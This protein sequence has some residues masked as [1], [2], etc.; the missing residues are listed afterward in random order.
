MPQGSLCHYTPALTQWLYETAFQ[1]LELD[2]EKEPK[3]KRVKRRMEPRCMWK[4][5]ETNSLSA[6]TFFIQVFWLLRSNLL[7]LDV[8]VTSPLW[9][10]K[11][12]AW[13]KWSVLPRE[14][15]WCDHRDGFVG[16]NMPELEASNVWNSFEPLLL[17][18]NLC[19]SEA[20][21]I[22][23]VPSGCKRSGKKASL[24]R[25][26]VSILSSLCQDERGWHGFAAQDP[27]NVFLPSDF[28]ERRDIR[29]FR[30]SFYSNRN[31]K[32]DC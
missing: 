18:R 20:T 22:M 21:N 12:E 31:C 15:S 27:F 8:V 16:L 14:R 5:W 32:S 29:D 13:C 2:E 9:K 11:L 30:D 26:A 28:A 23:F 7:A 24:D 3:Q 4:T 25:N 1:K 19:S 6:S 17:F 10:G